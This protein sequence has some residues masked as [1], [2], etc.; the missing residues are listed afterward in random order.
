MTEQPF[1][2]SRE[3]WA[4]LL[5][6]L[7]AA[8]NALLVIFDMMFHPSSHVVIRISRRAGRLSRQVVLGAHFHMDN[9]AQGRYGR[10][11]T[12]GCPPHRTTG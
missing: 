3:V 7:F 1:P 8:R 2:W 9:A 4:L 12:R 10:Q 5:D 6:Q 11:T